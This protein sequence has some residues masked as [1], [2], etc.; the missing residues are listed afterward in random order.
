[1]PSALVVDDDA[2]QRRLFHRLL[3]REGW[4]VIVAESGG[5]ALDA[6]AKGSYELLLSDVNLGDMNGI[7]LAKAILH[8]Q[9]KL[10][11]VIV[12]GL[13]Q[14]LERARDAG[15]ASCLLKPFVLE[16]LSRLV[17]A[18]SANRITTEAD[19]ELKKPVELA[20]QLVDLP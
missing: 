13:P 8:Q 15:F 16:E 2:S 10:R 19:V 9:P 11:V 5:A 7:D 20:V 18:P 14:N 6:F 12:S 1:M 4:T 3:E 17:K